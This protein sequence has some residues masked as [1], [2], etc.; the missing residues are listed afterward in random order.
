MRERVSEIEMSQTKRG[1]SKDSVDD[2]SGNN[3]K[4]TWNGRKFH[5]NV[6]QSRYSQLVNDPAGRV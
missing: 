2:G 5:C 6:T 3:L 4:G 1:V